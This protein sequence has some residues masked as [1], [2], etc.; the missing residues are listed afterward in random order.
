MFKED[1]YFD[2]QMISDFTA[3]LL[4]IEVKML[5]ESKR[6]IYIYICMYVYVYM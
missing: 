2:K 1:R 4:Y 6:Y 5:K 3:Q